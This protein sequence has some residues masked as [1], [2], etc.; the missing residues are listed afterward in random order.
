MDY[1]TDHTCNYAT[2][3]PIGLFSLQLYK[4][5]NVLIYEPEFSILLYESVKLGLSYRDNSI[6]F[7][8]SRRC[9]EG[10]V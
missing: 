9:R 1:V 7:S 3:G 10:N 6:G 5:L 2:Y 4:S 8:Y